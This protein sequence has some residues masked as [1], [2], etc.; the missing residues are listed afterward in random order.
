MNGINEQKEK[1]LLPVFLITSQ[2]ASTMLLEV[3]TI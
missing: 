1:R 3:W 2:D